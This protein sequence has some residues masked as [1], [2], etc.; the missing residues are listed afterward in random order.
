MSKS[1]H[2]VV[3]SESGTKFY[4][5]GSLVASCDGDGNINLENCYFCNERFITTGS[6]KNK[7][8]NE[9]NGG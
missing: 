2:S 5:N 7:V 9:T 4:C 6:G 1:N 3:Y 8:I